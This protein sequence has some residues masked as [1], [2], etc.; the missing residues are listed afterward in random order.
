VGWGRLL[1]Y[2]PIR[3]GTDQLCDLECRA[4]CR[5][6]HCI[7]GVARV[8]KTACFVLFYSFVYT[9]WLNDAASAG[10]H[11]STLV[12]YNG[13][14]LVIKTRK[15]FTFANYSNKFKKHKVFSIFHSVAPPIGETVEMTE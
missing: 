9:Y 4:N 3:G 12:Q 11:G 13:M 5:V 10:F 1:L 15:T 6:S 7:F 8:V 2:T 14:M